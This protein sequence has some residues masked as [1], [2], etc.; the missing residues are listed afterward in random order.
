M[1][2]MVHKLGLR[3]ISDEERSAVMETLLSLK[4]T[5]NL[6]SAL[7]RP[8]EDGKD[9]YSGMDTVVILTFLLF[10]GKNNKNQSNT[11]PLRLSTRTVL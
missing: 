10:L 7:A 2:R 9:I 6:G 11:L 3:D 8:R 1:K 4:F 5:P